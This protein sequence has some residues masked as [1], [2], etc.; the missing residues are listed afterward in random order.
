MDKKNDTQKLRWSPFQIMLMALGLVIFWH[1]RNTFWKG[2]DWNFGALSLG[3]AF[4]GMGI[5]LLRPSKLSLIARLG[6]LAFLWPLVSLLVDDWNAGR[7]HISTIPV[8]IVAAMS[9]FFVIC[10][11]RPRMIALMERMGDSKNW[12]GPD[13]SEPLDID[14]D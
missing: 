6:A 12:S 4:L 2:A 7:M 5:A 10:G 14:W 3:A 11:G 13:T 9:L 1:E 8:F